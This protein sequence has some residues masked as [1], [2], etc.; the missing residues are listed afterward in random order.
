MLEILLLLWIGAQLN[1][2]VWYNAIAYF[3]LIVA[4]LD[5][6]VKIYKLGVQSKE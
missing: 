6:L 2:P 4:F 3:L 5:L 1:A